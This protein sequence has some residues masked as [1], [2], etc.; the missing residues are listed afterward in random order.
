MGWVEAS[1]LEPER[2]A[3]FTRPLV[4]RYLPPPH[5]KAP[6]RDRTRAAFS[7]Q[8]AVCWPVSC[9]VRARGVEYQTPPIFQA[10]R[11]FLE[12]LYRRLEGSR[13]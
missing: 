13:R 6:P 3:W 9:A 12:S 8:A 1:G 4:A 2:T 10:L 5:T 7:F 11:I